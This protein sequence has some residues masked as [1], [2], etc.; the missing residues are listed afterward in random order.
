MLAL[1]Y[2]GKQRRWGLALVFTI[3]VML[4]V[5]VGCGG[6]GGSTPPPTNPGTPTGQ[7]SPVVSI[8]INGVTETVPNLVLNVE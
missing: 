7:T 3:F 8:T 1:G 6:G 5:G 2:R 4:A